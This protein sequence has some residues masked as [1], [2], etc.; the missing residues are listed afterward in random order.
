MNNVIGSV[1]FLF[2]TYSVSC[3]GGRPGPEGDTLPVASAGVKVP[4]LVNLTG[5][6]DGFNIKTGDEI[7]VSIS[8]LEGIPQP[9]SVQVYFNGKKAGTILSP[10]MTLTVQ[11]S[12][13]GATGKKALKITPYAGGKA[14]RS[15]T[16][17]VT[18]MSDIVPPVWRYRIV[19]T[20]PHDMGAYTQGLFYH[21]GLF[22]EGTG[23]E[24][25]S[26]LREVE[27][28]TGK[29]LR[30]LNLG[31][32]LFGEGITLLD[33]M[34]FQVTW[35]NKV[36]FVYRR[37]SFE[38]VKKV[39]YQTEGWGLTT[40]DGKIVMSDGS[41]I[42]YYI[43]PEMFTVVSQVEVYDNTEAVDS[44]NEL[45]YIDGEIWANIWLTDRIARIDPLSGKVLGY[46]DLTGLLQQKG[47]NPGELNGIAYDPDGK[48]VF[49]TGK[50]WPS[51][52]EIELLR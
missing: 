10:V 3:S 1:F 45:E 17:F 46:I 5:P 4:D 49:V 48:R 34:I 50:N 9:D 27:P 22:Y 36:G 7:P 18:V 26:S 21:N 30:Q 35:Q 44:L 33:D 37:D 31:A 42:L 51:L 29:I 23:Q 25:R 15:I 32:N 40:I 12:F 41:N 47:G 52:F 20:L 43:E 13:T 14:G 2:L 11:G 38:Q 24:T 19:K 16:R 6:A 28:E 8:S 39:Y